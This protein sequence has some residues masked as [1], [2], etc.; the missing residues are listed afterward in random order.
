MLVMTELR[1]LACRRNAASVRLRRS[2]QTAS[3]NPRIR[4][5]TRAI[6][7]MPRARVSTGLILAIA[8]LPAGIEF[9]LTAGFVW[10]PRTRTC[11][12]SGPA[13]S[14]LE[15]AAVKEALLLGSCCAP[16]Q[17]V[18]VGEAPEAADDVGVQFGPFE[19]CSV[20]E[21][22]EQADATLLVRQRFTV[23]ERQIEELPL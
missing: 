4:I 3:G 22:T 10:Q 15:P 20:A 17:G 1:S 8:H 6:R 2:S 23:L 16:K 14:P 13:E 21:R 7:K 18:A 19:H 12:L 5:T 9:E 11:S